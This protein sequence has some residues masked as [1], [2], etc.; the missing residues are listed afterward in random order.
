MNQSNYK[1]LRN[2]GSIWDN[3]DRGHLFI[4]GFI[5]LGLAFF[6][7]GILDRNNEILE[8]QA[9]LELANSKVSVLETE[10]LYGDN[11]SELSPSILEEEVHG[12][13]VQEK[14][15]IIRK[16]VI[17]IL[18]AQIEVLMP[19][20]KKARLAWDEAGLPQP[21]E[22]ANIYYDAAKKYQHDPTFLIS[23]AWA[24][25]RFRAEICS[26]K[27]KSS[28][29][30]LGC[31]QI[32]PQWVKELDFVETKEQLAG[33]FQT[34]VFAGAHIFRYYLDHR[35][36]K[37]RAI[38]AL[39]MYNYGARR[40]GHKVRNKTRFNGYAKSIMNKVKDLKKLIPVEIVVQKTVTV[41]SLNPL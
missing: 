36:S 3:V 12:N 2:I 21:E 35:Y 6:N 5:F 32:M 22:M 30:A 19:K 4:L 29:G 38:P 24:E 27:K 10:Y 23:I 18:A 15:T 39:Y 16:Q 41:D 7:K 8:L 17:P 11:P 9:A 33:D 31:M 37:D 34:N 28:A 40:Y 13:Y 26:G 14:E 20:G 1:L 25:S